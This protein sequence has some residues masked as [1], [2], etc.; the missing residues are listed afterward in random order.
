LSKSININD[1]QP[2]DYVALG[3]MPGCKLRVGEL[4]KFNKSLLLFWENGKEAGNFNVNE[5]VAFWAT[6]RF[7]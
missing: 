1:L 6:D 4:D 2:G 3:H 7:I 5:V